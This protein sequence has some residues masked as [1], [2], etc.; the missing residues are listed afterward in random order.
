MLE[1]NLIFWKNF[2]VSD[3]IALSALLVTIFSLIIPLIY[4]LYKYFTREKL[5]IDS[6]SL[7]LNEEWEDSQS[8]Y[9]NEDKCLIKSA[10][11]EQ[12]F[13]FPPMFHYY[14]PEFDVILKNNTDDI[15]IM[16][17]LYIRVNKI[18]KSLKPFLFFEFIW[19]SILYKHELSGGYKNLRFSI[20][21][22]SFF[23]MNNIRIIDFKFVTDVG[24]LNRNSFI[25]NEIIFSLNIEKA[26][27]IE[28]SLIDV[29][30]DFIV[31]KMTFTIE[32]EFNGEKIQYTLNNNCGDLLIH[33]KKFWFYAISWEL[34]SWSLEFNNLWK[35]L[36]PIKDNLCMWNF[37][38]FC[39]KEYSLRPK[40]VLR[41]D[42]FLGVDY[43]CEVDIDIIF[44]FW[45]EKLIK[46]VFIDFNFPSSYDT[47]EYIEKAQ[48]MKL[49]K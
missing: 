41:F 26:Y 4:Q 18:E 42:F 3:K 25:F 33:D 5:K 44:D 39:P 31:K 43:P 24:L 36:I 11:L 16:K 12:N 47:Q 13:Y 15:K 8:Y 21:N 9:I 35:F 48:K 40:D 28:L 46:N 19:E 30:R 32:C 22:C 14:F 49:K 17:N 27:D 10:Y 38:L 34:W 6:F 37:L 29:S 45:K 23:S 1:K 20:Q 2:S 7:K